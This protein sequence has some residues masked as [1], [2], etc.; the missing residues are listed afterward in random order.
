MAKKIVIVDDNALLSEAISMCLRW[1]GHSVQ[2][3]R[4]S[5]DAYLQILAEQPDLL[6]L[7]PGP[8]NSDGWQ[9]V[10]FLA[11]CEFTEIVP[12]IVVSIQDPDR[13]N[14]TKV[15]PFAYIQKPFDMG[16]LIQTVEKGLDKGLCL[17]NVKHASAIQEEGGI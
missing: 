12:I 11:E 1:R 6:I 9:L 8:P 3:C 13:R 16:Q 14:L 10:N 7:D 5:A 2:V 4:G 17:A 15:R